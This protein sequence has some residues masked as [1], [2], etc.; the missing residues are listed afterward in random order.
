MI[1]R[2]CFAA[3]LV[4][5]AGPAF[6]Q[7]EIDPGP[8]ADTL[9]ERQ[10]VFLALD[11]GTGAQFA[12]N[13]DGLD[14]RH[15]PWS[16]FKIANLMIA[17]ETGTA[18]G[19]GH[20]RLW[21][22]ARRPPRDFWPDGWKRDHTLKS[23][24]A[25]S[26]VW[27]FRDL[28]LEIGGETYRRTLTAWDYGN[29]AAADGNDAFWLDG[30]LQISVRE[31]VRFLER[32]LSSDLG[33]KPE[34]VAAF[35]A[36]SQ[37]RKADGIALHGKTGAGTLEEGFDGPFDGWL[38]GF[39]ARGTGKPVVYA[40]YVYGPSYDSIRTFRRDFAVTLLTHIDVLPEGW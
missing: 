40:L 1:L 23:A 32:A 22:P 9:G 30:S 15:A 19:L 39:V 2:Y 33:L 10:A 17:L 3:A 38:V 31:Q 6:S 12:L 5:W 21:D 18:T 28:A 13:P 34:T 11:T 35:R 4:L 37:L 16:T 27:Y 25:A 36:A 7:T 26:A 20:E 24:F 29:G 8:F 14:E